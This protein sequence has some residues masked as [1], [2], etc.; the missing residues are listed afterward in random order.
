MVRRVG[1]GLATLCFVGAIV[2]LL[3]AWQ[4]HSLALIMW[5]IALLMIGCLCLVVFK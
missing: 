2:V 4:Q 5:A 1:S 3:A